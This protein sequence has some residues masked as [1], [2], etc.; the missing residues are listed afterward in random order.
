MSHP[1]QA[2]PVAHLPGP[3]ERA[4]RAAYLHVLDADPASGPLP[5]GRAAVRRTL[6]LPRP[7][8]QERAA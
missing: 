1:A 3:A 8:A 6:P 4:A 2:T 7:A 5:A